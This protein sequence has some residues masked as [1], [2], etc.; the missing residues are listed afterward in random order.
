MEQVD[1]DA[2]PPPMD[3][4]DPPPRAVL[5]QRLHRGGAR[6]PGAARGAARRDGAPA[7]QVRASGIGEGYTDWL[8]QHWTGTLPGWVENFSPGFIFHL[9]HFILFYF[10]LHVFFIYFWFFYFHFLHSTS[11]FSLP[12]ASG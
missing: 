12:V 11:F 6:P 7:V 5:R 4:R 3:P 9:F 8:A 2:A 10:M 1:P